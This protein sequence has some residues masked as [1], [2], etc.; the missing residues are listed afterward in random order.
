[1]ASSSR[2]GEIRVRPRRIGRLLISLLSKEE[3][4]LSGPPVGFL[5]CFI[6]V[7]TLYFFSLHWSINGS[8][9]DLCTCRPP[10]YHNLHFC[11]KFK[12]KLHIIPDMEDTNRT[13]LQGC[14]Q[15]HDF[16][17]YFD[18]NEY[19]CLHN[20]FNLRDNNRSIIPHIS[21]CYARIV[22]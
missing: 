10:S 14:L 2:E 3:I 13:I 15:P 11:R 8:R 6:L 17:P 16:K 19:E 12:L 20:L 4:E 22:T 18:F 1:V 7:S 9:Y 5:A 21:L